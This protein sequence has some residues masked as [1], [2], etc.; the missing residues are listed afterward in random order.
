MTPPV[1]HLETLL[2]A[3]FATSWLK[4]GAR[5]AKRVLRTRGQWRNV[6]NE[7][8]RRR[9]S[10]HMHVILGQAVDST[11]T[12]SRVCRRVRLHNSTCQRPKSRFWNGGAGKQACSPGRVF[13]LASSAGTRV[14]RSGMLP[15]VGVV[16]MP[17]VLVH[18]HVYCRR[19]S[20]VRRRCRLVA[21]RL[22]TTRTRVDGPCPTG[23]NRCSSGDGGTGN[24]LADGFCGWRPGCLH[25]V[26]YS[27]FPDSRTGRGC[28][29]AVWT[30]TR[31]AARPTQ[32]LT[33]HG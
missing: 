31:S 6:L 32:G 18:V 28:D 10:S 16:T 1:R 25:F 22:T 17:G 11:Q 2:S 15:L 7:T 20:T 12:S 19:T 21:A 14:P 4:V 33:G 24:A 30:F 3:A 9:K 29:G 13:T 23:A 27:H 5:T 26:C 8:R